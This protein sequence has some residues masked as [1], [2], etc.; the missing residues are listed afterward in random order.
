MDP[1]I[2][3]AIVTAIGLVLSSAIAAIITHSGNKRET[4]SAAS[5]AAEQTAARAAEEKE[6]LMIQR[7]AYRDDQI[8]G[9]EKKVERMNLDRIKLQ[10]QLEI[11]RRLLREKGEEDEQSFG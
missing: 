5:E 11:C 10:E 6:E 8:L 1:T 9:L 4:K 7:L 3:V 2:A